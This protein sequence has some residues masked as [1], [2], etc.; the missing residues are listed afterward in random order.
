MPQ[1]QSPKRKV[2]PPQSQSPPGR[3][4]KMSPRPRSE[5]PRQRG[6]GRLARR[7]ALVTGGD[8][9]IGRAV[10]IAFAKEG[11]DVAFVY[12]NEHDDARRTVADIEKHGRRS[13]SIAGDIGHKS[14]CDR[15]VR[16]TVQRLGRLDILI[17]NAAEQHPQEDPLAI[18]ER[19]L[20]RTF[21]T[22]VF[23]MFFMT[24]A[25]LPQLGK[26]SAIV[27]T[28]S[29]TAYRGSP[30]LLDYASTKGAIV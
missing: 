3:E 21:R 1:K 13:F 9:G 17:N 11:A 27:N 16:R 18:S 6:A 5:D 10:A 19:Q 26:G 22:N 15:A 23:G 20:E 8:S 24:Q 2:H 29:V 7:V 12:L 28:A 25:A 30:A 4:N 14:F